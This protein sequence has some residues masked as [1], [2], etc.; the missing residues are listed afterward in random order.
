[1]VLQRPLL[2]QIE[3]TEDVFKSVSAYSTPS[4]STTSL[5]PQV[6]VVATPIL[7]PSLQNPNSETPPSHL[8]IFLGTAYIV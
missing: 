8:P 4:S 1:M 5:S 7:M 2:V 3:D 6:Y